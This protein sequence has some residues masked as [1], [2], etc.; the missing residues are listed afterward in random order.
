M[1]TTEKQIEIAIRLYENNAYGTTYG[2]GLY[3]KALY[4][5]TI[6]IKRPSVKY[7][8]DLYNYDDWMNQAKTDMQMAVLD[9][10]DDVKNR[11]YSWIQRYDPVT[12]QKTLVY[13]LCTL[14]LTT[15]SMIVLVGDV[16]YGVEERWDVEAKP[17]RQG[18]T[19]VKSPQLLATNGELTSW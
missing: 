11:L 6:D 15:L 3:R 19:G 18:S 17:C 10:V 14:D 2:K 5:G 13:G 8:I 4:N 9:A 1:L 16:T 7:L 12:K